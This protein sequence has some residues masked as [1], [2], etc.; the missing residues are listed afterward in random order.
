[1]YDVIGKLLIL[2]DRDRKIMLIR[3]QLG[4][5][6]P[7]RE[8]LRAQTSTAAAALEE[9]R[10]RAK[11][12]E[13]DRKQRELEVEAKKQQIGR[14]SLQQ[15]QT[16]KNEEYRALAHRDRDLQGGNL[17]TGGPA[18]GFDGAGRNHAA[19]DRRVKPGG[20]GI[21]DAG[22]QPVERIGRARAKPEG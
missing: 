20:R 19:A 6:E 21:E 9:A 5:I 10:T 16:K 17:H 4:R 7:D 12:I 13:S 8:T 3:E 11:L 2:Q 15:F 1:M 14:Y 22:G 18:V